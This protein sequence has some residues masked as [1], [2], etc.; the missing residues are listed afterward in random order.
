[1]RSRFLM[2]G[3][4]VLSVSQISVPILACGD[5]F[6]LSV[7]GQTFAR[8]YRAR[9]PGSVLIYSP[10]T[11]TR[12]V[13]NLR[14][15]LK[16][17]GHKVTVARDDVQLTQALAGKTEVILASSGVAE[18]VKKIAPAATVLPVLINPSKADRNA[19]KG[20]LKESDDVVKF[21][22]TINSAMN[23]RAKHRP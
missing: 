21:V 4:I 8:M 9:N 22:M 6:G 14:S 5:K 10:N 20:C 19:C 7:Q 16:N 18:T 15:A 1:M 11:P 13:D 23:D 2:A 17:V 12:D 3:V